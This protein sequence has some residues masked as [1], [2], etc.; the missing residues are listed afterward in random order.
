MFRV[1]GFTIRQMHIFD[2]LLCGPQQT[3]KNI[4]SVNC[5]VSIFCSRSSSRKY[6]V[7]SSFVQVLPRRCTM[8]I[9]PAPDVHGGRAKPNPL[10]SWG[11]GKPH[12]C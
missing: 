6:S 7:L 12:R 3:K 2:T 4:V 8:F 5:P 10:R 9:S 1:I 11:G